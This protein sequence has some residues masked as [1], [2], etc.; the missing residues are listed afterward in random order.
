MG[1]KETG[2]AKII[3]DKDETIKLCQDCANFGVTSRSVDFH[4]RTDQG[5]AKVATEIDYI[6]GTIYYLNAQKCRLDENLCGPD[7]VYFEVL[8]AKQTE[9]LM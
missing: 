2:E 7:A 1:L 9:V 6:T 4:G 5:C 8:S 3:I